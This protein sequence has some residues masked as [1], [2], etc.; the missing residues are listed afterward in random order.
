MEDLLADRAR[1]QIRAYRARIPRRAPLGR[2]LRA[3]ARIRT[4]E[5]YM[6]EVQPGSSRGQ[7][8]FIE[9]HCPICEAAAECQGLCATELDVFRAV[10]APRVTVERTE[11]IQSGA[12]RCAYLVAPKP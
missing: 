1:E 2:R 7:Y 5:G 10:L 8:L 4:E 6:A 12:R 3:L 11:H 9:N